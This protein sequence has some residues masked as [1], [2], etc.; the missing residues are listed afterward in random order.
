MPM[1]TKLGR[2]G[3]CNEEL[4]SIKSQD[5]II[6]WSCKAI[7]N[8]KSVISTTARPMATKFGKVVT[9]YEKLPPTKSHNPLNT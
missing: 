4:P 7:G 2:V 3:I 1:T 9:Y 5:P 6:T 8:I